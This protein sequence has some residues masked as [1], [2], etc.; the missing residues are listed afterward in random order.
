MITNDIIGK[1][2]KS[3]TFKNTLFV[4]KSGIFEN[5]YLQLIMKTIKKKIAQKSIERTKCIILCLCS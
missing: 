2:G 1:K 4:S 5:E 3:L